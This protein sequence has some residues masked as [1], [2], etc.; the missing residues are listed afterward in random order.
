MSA[1]GIGTRA[2][3]GTAAAVAA[4]VP[5]PVRPPRT[6]RLRGAVSAA[7]PVGVAV[8]DSLAVNRLD[9]TGPALWVGLAAAA[10]LLAR[11]RLPEAAL[12]AGIPGLYVGYLSFAPL[13]ALYSLAERRRGPAVSAAGAAVVALAQFLPYPLQEALPPSLD[14]E[15]ALAA[16]YSCVLA[17]GAVVLGRGTRLRRERLREVF[18]SRERENRLL[19]E[20]VLATERAR[21]ARE[22]HDVVA[23][24]VSHISVRA[25]ALQVSDPDQATVREGAEAIRE[26][27]VKTIHE[28]QHMVGVLRAAG[29][30]TCEPMARPRISDVPALIRDSGLRVDLDIGQVDEPAGRRPE[31]VERAVYR[32]VQECLTNVRK[33]AP[34]AHVEIRIAPRDAGLHLEVRNGPADRSATPLDLPGGGHGLV[35]LRERALLLGGTFRHGPAPDGGFVVQ[36][37]FPA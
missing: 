4:P 27:A 6:R 25:G 3:P 7:L 30:T 24:H 14:R 19:A 15:T 28:L 34:G 18:E 20:R 11:R 21:L 32:T 17:A 10:A 12:L 9:A 1:P 23:H 35:G 5:E 8:V 33:H 2:E 16:L 26:L 31:M 36:A 22:M 29:G 37:S 13:I